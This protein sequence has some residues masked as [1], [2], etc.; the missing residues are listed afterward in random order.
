MRNNEAYSLLD[1]AFF[2]DPKVSLEKQIEAEKNSGTYF[3][4]FLQLHSESIDG[5]VVHVSSIKIDEAKDE[6]EEANL[7]IEYEIVYT[8]Q[9]MTAEVVE[10]YR[11]QVQEVV[12]KAVVDILEQAVEDLTT[13][14]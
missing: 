9:K 14:K 3:P 12:S 13:K 1:P 8:P 4:I 5:W 2:E 11:P 7:G 6:N 10:Q